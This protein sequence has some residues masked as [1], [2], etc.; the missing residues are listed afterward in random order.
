MK[1]L[2][3]FFFSLPLFT[4]PLQAEA[5]QDRLDKLS[6]G[7]S[8]SHWYWERQDKLSIDNYI[9][10]QDIQALKDLGIRHVRIPF[11]MADLDNS[12]IVQHLKKDIQRFIDQ[13][14]AVMVSAFGD[15]YNR[16]VITTSKAPELLEKL[17]QEVI[18]PFSPD[19]IF[20][21]IA[22]EPSVEEPEAWSKIQ[23][24]LIQAARKILPKHTL[25]TSTPLKYGKKDHEWSMFQAFAQMIP[26]EDD[27]VVY[28]IHFYEPYL[29]THQGADWD[30]NTAVFVKNWD[31]PTN[32]VNSEKV[33]KALDPKA[34]KWIADALRK[35]WT[36]Q[37]LK[38]SLSPILD[39]RKKHK[40][41]VMITEFGVYKPYVDTKSRLNWLMDVV[42]ILN[43]YHFP[44]TFWDYG[45][46]FGLFSKEN[47]FRVLDQETASA[48]TLSISK[49]K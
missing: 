5:P 26:S 43:E 24:N 27:N 35:V 32:S 18:L 22:N 36:H 25:I 48:L 21:Q 29:F 33:I 19:H 45:G 39:W 38:E 28:A 40:R 31:Y 8:I 14:I 1:M 13:K 7:I 49:K 20:L 34:P 2:L 46:G 9:T 47:G 37:D 12:K 41:P 11:E 42:S 3:G 6:K 30:P 15:M 44:W 10:T 23:D 4:L 16:E 17:C